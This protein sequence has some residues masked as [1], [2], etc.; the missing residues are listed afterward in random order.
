MD[1]GW[2]T[3]EAENVIFEVDIKKV[4]LEPAQIPA[5]L[6]SIPEVEHI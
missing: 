2:V 6:F 5:L 1:Q 3:V 4:K